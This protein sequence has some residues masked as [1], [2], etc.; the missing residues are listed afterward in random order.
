MFINSNLQGSP[1]RFQGLL[2]VQ[3]LWVL[4]GCNPVWLQSWVVPDWLPDQ[5]P[6][7]VSKQIL[8]LQ[9]D[10]LH[11]TGPGQLELMQRFIRI[12]L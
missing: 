12:N 2:K 9:T 10:S 1:D 8:L 5:V 7:G 4:V 6:N 11:G 3:S